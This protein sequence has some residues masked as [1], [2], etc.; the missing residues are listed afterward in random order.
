MNKKRAFTLSETLITIGIIGIVAAITIP[1]LVTNYQKQQTVTRLKQAYSILSNA[2]KASIEDNGDPGG[3]TYMI[4]PGEYGASSKAFF[5]NYFNDY[6]KISDY[7]GIKHT[8]NRTG[9]CA[10]I[11]TYG[12][13]SAY[14]VIL[15]NGIAFTFRCDGTTNAEIQIDINGPQGPNRSGRDAFIYRI[16]AQKGLIPV[17]DDLYGMKACTR[18]RKNPNGYESWIGWGCSSVI[19]KNSWTIPADYPWWD[20]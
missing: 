12:D 20:L 15:L 16:N 4:K 2:Y 10:K 3:W 17:P 9:A 1:V 18:T 7:C 13:S 8:E 19:M 11:F 14:S 5:F 6:L